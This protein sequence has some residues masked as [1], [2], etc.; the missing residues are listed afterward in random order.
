MITCHVEGSGHCHAVTCDQSVRPR[1]ICP[2]IECPR[3]H[4]SSASLSQLTVVN[5]SNCVDSLQQP[6]RALTLPRQS[7]ITG[8]RLFLEASPVPLAPES[9][10]CL[11]LW[12]WDAA[13]TM[14]PL[15]CSLVELVRW[16]FIFL[17]SKPACNCTNINVKGIHVCITHCIFPLQLYSYICIRFRTTTC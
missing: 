5:S 3:N 13:V 14:G 16:F 12:R 6:H 1:S 8:V 11:D 4:L 15:T 7:W 17:V 9:S 2:V 10:V